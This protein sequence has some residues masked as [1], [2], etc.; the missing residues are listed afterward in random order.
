MNGLYEHAF[1][2]QTAVSILHFRPVK[3]R[4]AL[5]GFCLMAVLALFWN[6]PK[7]Q[8]AEPSSSLAG[9]KLSVMGDSIS[10]FTG[11]QPSDYNIFYP[12]SGEI[13][14]VEQTWWHQV[15]TKTGMTLCTNASSS[16]T[17]MTGN[18]LAMDGSAPGCSTRRVVDLRGADGSVPDVIIIYMGINDFSRSRTP[19][20]FQAPGIRTEGEISVFSEAYEIMIQKIKVLYPNAAVYCCTLPPRCCFVE[21]DSGLAVNEI[22]V[23]VTAYNDQIRAIAQAYGVHVIDLFHLSGI[24][25]ANLDLFLSDGIHPNVAGATLIANCVTNALYQN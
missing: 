1:L 14:L 18:S 8:A 13:T 22:G 10:T 23:Q 19:G 6:A 7:A 24:N 17:N 12:E 5:L 20:T 3:K 2:R 4:S 16:N 21:G 15:L 25:W 11:Q 9:K